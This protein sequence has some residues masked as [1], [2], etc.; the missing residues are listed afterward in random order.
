MDRIALVALALLPACG[1][2]GGGDGYV[3]LTAY[4]LVGT[5]DFAA[6]ASFGTEVVIPG[7][8]TVRSDCEVESFGACELRRCDETPWGSGGWGSPPPP[9]QFDDAGMMSL[10]WLDGLLPLEGDAR[11]AYWGETDA[12]P[13]GL[14]T[15]EA[16]GSRVPRLDLPL[17]WPGP[18]VLDPVVEVLDGDPVVR[19]TPPAFL[20]D[21]AV[22]WLSDEGF[23]GGG[24]TTVSC[25]VDLDEGL[26]R[27]PAEAFRTVR[28]RDLYLGAHLHSRLTFEVQA[29]RIVVDLD[30]TTI[31]EKRP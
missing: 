5:Y 30:A 19:W 29:Y 15:L 6:S 25:E 14:V 1:S 9:P 18:L 27:M 4:D 17:P 22:V 7:A 16:T 3:N 24:G 23:F 28:W 20:P 12:V 31:R 26:V 10:R 21:E 8:S 11:H 13:A 2:Q